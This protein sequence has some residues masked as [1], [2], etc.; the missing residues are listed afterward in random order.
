MMI[1]LKN[2]NYEINN[3]IIYCDGRLR[4]K[5]KR[6]D[7]CVICDKRNCIKTCINNKSKKHIVEKYVIKKS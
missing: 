4:K 3:L 6:T 5:D 7:I 2:D 1:R